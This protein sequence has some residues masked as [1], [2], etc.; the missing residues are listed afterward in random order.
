MLQRAASNAYSWWWASHIRTKQSKWLEQNLQDME[1]KVTDMLTIIDDDGDSFAQRAEMYYKKRPELVSIV[2]ES[3]RAYRALAERFDHLSK[4]LQSANRTIASVFPEQ[5]PFAMD[6]EDDENVSQTSTS[7][8][9]PNEPCVSK[10]SILKAPF[11]KKDLRSQSMFLSRKGQLKRFPSSGLSKDEALDEMDKLLKEILE[12]QTEREYMKSS[13]EHGYKKFCEIEN[14]ITEKQTRVCHLQDEFGIDSVIDDNEAQTLMATRALKSCQE[15]LDKLKERHEQS[16]EEARVESRRIKHVNQK[17]EALRNK[18]NS[19]QTNQQEKHTYVSPTT[20][21]DDM[22]YEIDNEEKEKQD[23]EVLQKKMKEQL[24]VDSN[25]SLTMAQLAEKIDDLVQRVIS[26]EIAVFSENALVNRLKS[27]ADELQ[28]HVKS[29]EEDK[30]ALIEGSDVMNKRI[31]ELEGELSRVKDLVKT[32]ID[33]NNSLK[34]SFTEAICNINH[35]SVKLQAV[36]MD[37]EVENAGLS[38]EVKT[39]SD[40]KADRG[41]EEHKIE[42]APD[43]SSALKDTAIKLEGKDKDVSADGESY[44]DSESS[45]KFDVDSK[46]G[47]E[48][49]EEDKA[50]KKYLSETAS[51]IPDTDTEEVETDEEEQPNWRQL[52]LNGLDDREKILLDEYSSVLWNYKEVRKKLNEVDKKNRD[53]FFELALQIRELKNAVAAR[54]GEIQSLR[55]K[56][57]FVD[58]NKDG[59]SVE[60]EGPRLSASQESTLTESI[61]TSPV[62]QGK[63]ESNEVIELKESPKDGNLVELEGPCRSAGQEPTLTESIQTSPVGR[64]KVES[65]EKVVEPTAHG[66]FKEPPKKMGENVMQVKPV[67]QSP[68]V[69]TVEDKIRS[70]IDNL[71]EENLEFWLRFSTCFHQIQKYQTSVQDLKAELSTLREKK[72][73]EGSGKRQSLKSEARPIYSHFREIETELT[74]W[75]ENN[76]VLTDEVQGR[77]SSLCNIQEEI[78]RVTNASGHAGQTELSEY[79]AAKFQGEVL[80]MKQENR[81][82]ANELKAGFARV[83]QLKQEVEEVMKNLEKELGESASTTQQSGSRTGRPRI[84]LR[85]FLFGIKLKNKR[86]SKGPSMFACGHPTLQRQHSFLTE[87]TESEPSG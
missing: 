49:V 16:T 25:A 66:R 58:E 81:K 72:N 87:P 38:Q 54:D 2:E 71:L 34:I 82:V 37:E 27:D 5:V 9:S 14:H 62:D 19:P 70:G 12:M 20:E 1:E 40:A 31:N 50:E 44:V 47:L 17:F 53:G 77:Y 6:E 74:L 11:P 61:Q 64:G 83:T 26:L 7:S 33:Q 60:L 3:Y 76:A 22:V 8:P 85:F 69:L 43:D 75:L 63:V 42:L 78:A 4:D 39:G 21:I 18:F 51:S 46:K 67:S 57:S 24:E 15:S 56:M 30:E 10:Q 13:Y 23:L 28:A 52:Y 86:Q 45:N 55:R 29:L 65:N 41:T 68:S 32:V 35:L 48:L 84:P 59:N 36:K 80:N 79:Q 73:Q